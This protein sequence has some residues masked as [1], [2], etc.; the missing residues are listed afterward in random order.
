MRTAWDKTEAG[1][2]SNRLSAKKWRNGNGHATWLAKKRRGRDN[3]RTRVLSRIDPLLRCARCGCDD[4]RLLEIN[5]LNGGGCQEFKTHPHGP[6][7]LYKAILDGKRSVVDL[8]LLCGP[9]NRLEYFE[10]RFLDVVG[11]TEIKW[12]PAEAST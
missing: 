7:P 9:C 10:R 5:H 3:R 6:G 2:E 1:R 11:R 4:W 12:T 8:N